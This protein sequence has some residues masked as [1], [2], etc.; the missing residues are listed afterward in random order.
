[1]STYTIAEVVGT[2]VD[3]WT[4][5]SV[6]KAELMDIISGIP[7]YWFNENNPFENI[8]GLRI[9][10]YVYRGTGT[11][12]PETGII[13]YVDD[14]VI[15][16]KTGTCGDYNLLSATIEDSSKSW[17]EDQ[18]N[19]GM[20][21]I[22]SGKSKGFSF[23]IEDTFSNYISVPTEFPCENV[24][25][26]I[27]SGTID[28]D[29]YEI[30][31]PVI[32][33]TGDE[34]E[35]DG[36]YNYCGWF[37]TTGGSYSGFGDGELILEFSTYRGNTVPSTIWKIDR[38]IFN[39]D[40]NIDASKIVSRVLSK[41][42][43]QCE[44]SVITVDS[45]DFTPLIAHWGMQDTYTDGFTATG[46]NYISYYDTGGYNRPGYVWGQDY[47]FRVGTETVNVNYQDPE[48]GDTFSLLLDLLG[49]ELIWLMRQWS[50]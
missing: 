20:F 46:T 14:V 19:G 1:M 35:T 17:S 34:G 49:K 37:A 8:Y 48:V 27:T 12:P 3:T 43:P 16:T 26:N 47:Y 40:L 4:K 41:T 24:I 39:V 22:T 50:Q 15:N 5:V 45:V 44:T 21:L 6:T 42:T 9:D 7:E 13:A 23:K 31:Y 36:F 30:R 11:I 28:G 25:K 33:S 29:T 18:F 10:A 2:T 32:A 38:D